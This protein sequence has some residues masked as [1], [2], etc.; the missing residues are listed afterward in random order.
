MVKTIIDCFAAPHDPTVHQ[1]TGTGSAASNRG[2]FGAGTGSAANSAD[3]RNNIR[4]PEIQNPTSAGKTVFLTFDDGPSAL[5][6]K[7]LD[8][9]KK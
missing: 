3:V 7:V 2:S 9:L 6:G 5:T 1:Q 8:I 4:I